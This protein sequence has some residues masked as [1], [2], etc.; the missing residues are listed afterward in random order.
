MSIT[1]LALLARSRA[2]AV[3]RRVGAAAPARRRVR[4]IAQWVTGGIPDRFRAGRGCRATAR[5]LAHLG[6]ESGLRGLTEMAALSPPRAPGPHVPGRACSPRRAPQLAR[7]LLPV[8]FGSPSTPLSAG[9]LR[10]H[11]AICFYSAPSNSLW[12]VP[13]SSASCK[14]D[15]HNPPE[16]GPLASDRELLLRREAT[17]VARS[18]QPHSPPPRTRRPAPRTP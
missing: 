15:R 12:Q 8:T 14:Y 5:A 1:S 18:A 10:M 11:P 13:F 7:D 6:S 3:F 17:S 16:L 2:W 4:G 9:R